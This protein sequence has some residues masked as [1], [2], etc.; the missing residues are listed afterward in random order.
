MQ[1]Q[2][3]FWI[4]ST[5]AAYAC[6]NSILIFYRRIF[7]INNAYRK[8]TL[9]LLILSAAWFNAVLIASLTICSSLREYFYGDRGDTDECG[10]WSQMMI[11]LLIIEAVIDVVILSLPI[12]MAFKLQLPIKTRVALAGLF[13]L[14]GFAVITNVV[15]IAYLAFP[16]D[17]NGKCLHAAAVHF[18]I[19]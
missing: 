11:S 9:A 4:F 5:C 14:G 8:A 19:Y 10:D 2:L 7:V 1:S 15:R 16:P 17:Y 18:T 13:A 6:K 3:L 12:H